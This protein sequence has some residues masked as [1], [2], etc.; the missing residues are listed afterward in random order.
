[1]R[2]STPISPASE[3]KAICG[4][5][6]QVFPL[7]EVSTLCASLKFTSLMSSAKVPLS[8]CSFPS[9]VFSGQ[10]PPFFK[11][12]V[13]DPLTR[14]GALR[15]SCNKIQSCQL[16]SLILHHYSLMGAELSDLV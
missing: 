2:L 9:L 8:V 12:A 14:N 10:I 3:C 6:P 5:C 11:F 13:W 7:N 4:S 15:T 16:V 1:M